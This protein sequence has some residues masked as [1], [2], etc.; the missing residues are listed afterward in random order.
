MIE[1]IKP[2]LDEDFLLDNAVARLLYH[3]HAVYQPIIDY[4]NHLSPS[5][6]A[7]DKV[8]DNITDLW[9]EG[10]HY[11][12]RAMRTCGVE[13]HYIT[14]KASP[15]EKFRKWAEVVPKT[16]RNPLYHWTHLELQRYFGSDLLL[17]PRTSDEIYEHTNQLVRNKEHSA[18]GLLHK[19]QVEVICTTDDP[20]SDLS[21]HISYAQV[22]DGLSMSM[23]FRPDNILSIEKLSLIHI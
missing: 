21:D 15:E 4:H 18:R 16:M 8:F 22:D 9:I 23:T 11:K 1:E 14:G 2:F 3:D 7:Q 5:H 20:T 17:S 12:W 10:D 6:I 19:M 13:E